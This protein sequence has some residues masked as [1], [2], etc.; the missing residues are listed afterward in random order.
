MRETD[1][2]YLLNQLDGTGSDR[3]FDAVSKLKKNLANE[4]PGYLL[5]KY[6][7]SKSWQHRCSCVY[8]S[9]SFS[10]ES[11]TALE[12]GLEALSD[13]S[14]YVRYR[15]CML[16]AWSLNKKAL[17]HLREA[18]AACNDNQTQE[19]L[20]AAIDAITSQNSNFF[21]DRDHSGHMTLEIN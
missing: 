21:I 18:A 15:A 6:R 20:K 9:I 3:E 11:C 13:R 1:I 7:S 2:E 19:D 4:L 8:H 10:R 16:L 12:L 5:S 17:P 14:K